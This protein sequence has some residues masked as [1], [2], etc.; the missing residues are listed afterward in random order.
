MSELDVKSEKQRDN[1]QR[2]FYFMICFICSKITI[3]LN[4]IK[5]RI[6][7]IRK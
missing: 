5:K 4:K 7:V 1:N 3:K 2:A 6:H